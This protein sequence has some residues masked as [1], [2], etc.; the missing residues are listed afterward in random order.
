MIE[1][2][3]VW[4]LPTRLFH[5]LLVALFAF[6]WWSAEN[7]EMDWHRW[8]GLGVLALIAFRLVWGV[9]GGST[10]RFASFVRSPL[11]VIGYLTGKEPHAA[12]GHNPL[13]GWSVLALLAVI[14]L[15]L[16]SGLFAVDTDGL[17]SGYLS[18]LVTFEQGRQAAEMH[19]FAFNLAMVLIAVHLA[20][21]LFYRVV[22][23][24]N[25]VAPMVTGRDAELDPVGH[26]LVP[27]GP[28]R[29]LIAAALAAVL[30]WWIS[31]GAGT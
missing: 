5:W 30:A 16:W 6:S 24:R 20:A 27:A 22:K 17:E 4:D 29:F 10:A 13:G 23:R 25:L 26:G 8:S 1:K 3:R 14:A 11:R 12:A 9:I 28:V 15:Q 18:H 21:I 31:N 2:L 19:E 7:R